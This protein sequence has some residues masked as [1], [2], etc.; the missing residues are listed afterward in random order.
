MKKFEQLKSLYNNM[1]TDFS[2][3][4]DSRMFVTALTSSFDQLIELSWKVLK[5]YMFQDLGITAA[6]TGSPKTI[7]KLAYAQQLI[8]D[9]DFWI[10]LWQ[11]RNDDTHHYNE[12]EARA[13]AARIQFNYLP[14]FSKFIQSLQELIPEEPDALI[15][16]PDSLLKASLQSGIGFD[17]FLKK[18][19]CEN[20]LETDLDVVKK[21]DEIKE[22][23][24]NC[25]PMSVFTENKK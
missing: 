2:V 5:E 13:Y 9:E 18:V 11:D 14:V 1:L 25:E 7:I 22:N 3:E 8:N 6:R 12:L 23:Y 4:Q 19:K 20:S 21:W 15:T 17:R 10:N 24:F 16:I